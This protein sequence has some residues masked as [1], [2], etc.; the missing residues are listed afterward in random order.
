MARRRFRNQRHEPTT[1][2]SFQEYLY[3]TPAPQTSR[4]ELLRLVRGS[5]VEY[6]NLLERL[7]TQET[8]FLR[9]PGLFSAFA[10]QVAPERVALKIWEKDSELRFL[11]A[12]ASVTSHPSLFANSVSDISSISGIGI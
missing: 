5:N 6:D 11:K 10:Q 1:E 12:A 2:R 9:Y 8:S 3:S 4:L 7:L